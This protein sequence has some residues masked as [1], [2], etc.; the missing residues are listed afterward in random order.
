MRASVSTVMP[1][2]SDCKMMSPGRFEADVVGSQLLCGLARQRRP[3]D[4]N[5]AADE[6]GPS[7]HLA[8]C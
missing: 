8:I 1:T 3:A 6:R 4:E 7:A 2:R 5:L